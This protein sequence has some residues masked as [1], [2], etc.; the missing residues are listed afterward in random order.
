MDDDIRRLAPLAASLL[1][2]E[3]IVFIN[4][5]LPLLLWS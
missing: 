5:A 2:A 1:V 4:Y 3:I